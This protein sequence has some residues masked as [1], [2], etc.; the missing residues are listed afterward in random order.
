MAHKLVALIVVLGIVA[1][2]TESFWF[3]TL[4]HRRLRRESL[5]DASAVAS[6]V[7]GWAAEPV[8]AGDR[9]SAAAALASLALERRVL[10]ARLY[11]A[12][13]NILADYWRSP[14]AVPMA[15]LAAGQDGSRFGNGSLTLERGVFYQGR[16]AGFLVIACEMDTQHARVQQRVR[17]LVWI[18]LVMLLIRA[19]IAFGLVRVLTEPVCYLAGL[20]RH[21]SQNHDYSVRAEPRSSG[22]IA[23]LI[24]AFNEMLD[25][26][27]Q[28]D[29][30]RKAAEERLRQSEQRYALAARGSNEGLW[31]FDAT[32]GMTYLS[33]RLHAM[34]GGPEAETW[35]GM[36]EWFRLIHPDDRE[37]MRTT[38]DGFLTSSCETLELEYRIRHR[39][40]HYRW[41]LSHGAAV[42]DAGGKVLRIAGSQTDITVSKTVDPVTGLPNRLL[43]LDRLQSR[44]EAPAAERR[45]AAVLYLDL[46]QFTLLNNLLGHASADTLLTE[47]AGRLHSVV[48][49]APRRPGAPAPLIARM[50]GDEFAVLFSGIEQEDLPLLAGRILEQLRE[51]VRI[52][53]RGLSVSASLGIA[54]PRSG[55][56]PEDWARNADTAMY[57]AK[58][59]GK[60]QFA[61]FEAG[62][63]ERV[64]ARMEIA[65]DLRRAIEENQLRLHYQPLVSL[66]EKKILAFE[67]LVR[68][69]HP[70]R[71]LLGPGEFIPVAEETD[72][73]LPLGRWVLREACRQMA[74]WQRRFNPMPPLNLG[75][76]V[77]AR[78]LHAPG[79]L[80]EVRQV[81]DESGFNPRQLRIEIT[82]SSIMGNSEAALST[83]RALQQMQIRLVIDDFGTGYSSLSYLRRLPFT[84][85]KIDRSFI[86]ELGAGDGSPE[87]V[88]T[89]LDLARALRM[90]VVA[91]GVETAEQAIRLQE[92][93]C[94]LVQGFYFARPAGA[95]ETEARICNR[96]VLPSL[97]AAELR[98][99][100]EQVEADANPVQ[101][102]CC[103]C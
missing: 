101:A 55:D 4:Q 98:L 95:E 54:L 32:T 52:G 79:L 38:I 9:R 65:T 6:T 89:I 27:E 10:G 15:S 88:R 92:L 100:G 8:A 57:H 87:I 45:R 30:A 35:M 48:Q 20:A 24:G 75:V 34:Y 3:G 78:Q 59:K 82:E 76:N 67:A 5:A 47:I 1:S 18:L 28:H 64:V 96:E 22:E 12:Q 51:P 21:V 102:A 39:D 37:S 41:V 97:E 11:D 84:G 90:V 74:E 85:L 86:Q 36:E 77:S 17:V 53:D 94:D 68:W 71:G 26:I 81:L 66:R 2:L 14:G 46:D 25:Q 50:G 70:E 69:Q 73:I 33:P 29:R 7:T 99:I 60:A 62:M 49:A 72:L 83:L 19:F 61:L 103:P 42:R 58:R 63:R 23:V 56:T 80:R 93:G 13:G 91:E 40:G 43:F 44:L 31:D 16:R